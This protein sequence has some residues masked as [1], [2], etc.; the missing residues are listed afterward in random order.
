MRIIKAYPP[1]FSKI[2]RTFPYI[3]GRQGI[4][5]AWGD[6]LYN[7]SGIEVTTPIL[8]HEEVH[9]SSQKHYGLTE[10]WEDYLTKW[11]F[12]YTE[13]LLAHRAEWEAYGKDKEKLGM[14]AARLSSAL[15]GSMTT[16]TQAEWDISHG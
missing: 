15:Y 1:I 12:R 3:T 9:G 7:P 16:F 13:E 2:K 10:W 6:I 5:Y 14:I 4:L 11:Q 8:A